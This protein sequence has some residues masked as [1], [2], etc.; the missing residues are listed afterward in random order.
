MAIA[1]NGLQTGL[2]RLLKVRLCVS[3]S[4]TG[5][6]VS[7]RAGLIALRREWFRYVNVTADRTGPGGT[8]NTTAATVE[9]YAGPET[10]S[11]PAE[12]V[13]PGQTNVLSYGVD[14]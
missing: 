13:A 1:G 3:N 7:E 4:T 8:D 12:M 10:F 14:I 11:V 9:A 6:T 2:G 5:D